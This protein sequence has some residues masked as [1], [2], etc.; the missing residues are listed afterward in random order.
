MKKVIIA[1]GTGFIGRYLTT[2]FLENGYNVMV[3]SRAPEHL[4]W[5]VNELSKVFEKT[6]LVIN[7]AGRSINCR[8]T[9]KNRAAIINSRIDT[10]EVI[11]N[12]IQ[13]C[14]NPPELWINASA[15]GIYQ[16]SLTTPMTEDSPVGNDF[17]A[18]VVRKWE[19]SFFDFNFF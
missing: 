16:A 2:R 18:E 5:N 14:K 11:G 13:N 8:H 7:L 6:D 12:A 17:L 3:V 9:S 19:T 15:T 10:T 1:G 4:Q